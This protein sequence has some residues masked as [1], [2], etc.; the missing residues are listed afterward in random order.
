MS[1][2]STKILTIWQQLFSSQQFTTNESF[3]ALGGHTKSADKLY[4]LLV[5]TFGAELNISTTIAY[6]YPTIEKQVAYIDALLKNTKSTHDF[7]PKNRQNNQYEPVAIIGMA[8]RFPAGANTPQEYWQQLI[9][10]QDVLEE[11]PASRWDVNAYYHPNR[12]MRGKMVTHKG[13]FIT[14]HDKFD[15]YFFHIAPTE[16]D[17]LDPNQ[18]IA[19]ETSWHALEN[20][21]IDPASLE[22][23][24]TGVFMGVMF[25]DYEVL[26][27]RADLQKE[28]VGYLNIGTSSGAVAGRISYS[29][30]L[31]GPS[32]VIDTACSSSLTALHEACQHLHNQEC[33]LALAGGIN[34]MLLPEVSVSFS[35]ANMLSPDQC[36][37]SFSDDANGYVRS[38]GCGIVVLKRLSDAQK[39][40]DRILA[41]IKS[42]TVNQDGA[43]SG[44]TVPNR[45]AQEK[46]L[47][48]ALE[49]AALT[50]QDID[51]LEAH[52]TGTP[53]GDPI[54]MGAINTVYQGRQAPLYIGS[55]KSNIGHLE[56]ASG[57]AGLMKVILSLQ[58]EM[59]P[60]N[61]HFHALNPRINLDNIPAEIVIKPT[62]WQKNNKPR[63]AGISSFGF[64]GTNVHV[65][66][67]E[68]PLQDVTALKSIISPTV[69][70]RQRFWVKALDVAKLPS[71]DQTSIDED[72]DPIDKLSSVEPI[73]D[74]VREQVLTVLGLPID[75]KLHDNI[76]FFSLGLDSLMAAGLGRRINK[77]FPTV[78]F[79]I[80]I[81]F[82]YPS[83][84][85]LS[86]YIEAQLSGIKPV[87]AVNHIVHHIS[88]EPIAIIGMSCRFPGGAN[89]IEKFWQLL[90]Q[91]FDGGMDIPKE[92]WNMDAYYNT[93]MDASGKIYVRRAGL[94]TQPIDEFD[95]DFFG[96]SPREASYLDPQQRILLEETWL[97][98]EQAGIHPNDLKETQTS[99]FLGICS[100]DYL[101]RL[102]Q[103]PTT[104]INSHAGT[105][106][107]ASTAAGR[108]SYTLGLQGAS[109]AIDTACSSSLVAVHQACQNLRTNESNMAI[110]GGVNTILAPDFMATLCRMHML[111]P[112]G[113]C[114]TFDKEADGFMRGEGC[115]VIILK[116]LNDAQADGDRILA[117]IKGSAVNQDGATSGLT[118]PNGLAQE[119][120][121]K[122]ALQQA[123]LQPADIDY[124]E[125]HGTGTHLGD[126]IE[127]SA[128]NRVFGR[129]KNNKRALPLTI[130]TVKT[131]IGHLEA[132]AGIAGVIK[133]ILSMQHEKIPPH[134][135]FNALNPAINLDN[136][137]AQIPLH[138]MDWKK[139]EG[140]IRRAGVS[141]FG[142]SG[143]NAHIVLE[144]AP[145][146]VESSLRPLLPKTIFNRQRYWAQDLQ[147]MEFKNI[148]FHINPERH[149]LLQHEIFIPNSK[150]WLY[151]TYLTENWPDFVEDHLI[152]DSPVIAGATYVSALLSWI[153]EVKLGALAIEDMNFIE[154]L[155]VERGKQYHV[156]TLIES[157]NE[158]YAFSIYS[159]EHSDIDATWQL[160]VQGNL[161][162]QHK[163]R[164]YQHKVE[165]RFLSGK[166]QYNKTE[167]L[168]LFKN[169]S[170]T[171]GDHFHWLEEAWVQDH[172]VLA[173]FRQ[174]TEEEKSAAYVIHPGLM[175]SIFQ[176]AFAAFSEHHHRV[177]TPYIPFTLKKMYF[178]LTQTQAP[179][180]CHILFEPMPEQKS[181]KT[182][183][184]LLNDQFVCIGEVVDLIERCAPKEKLLQSVLNK[185]N[186]AQWFY[187]QVWQPCH[188]TIHDFNQNNGEII[189]Y[190][191]RHPDKQTGLIGFNLNLLAFIQD[192]ILKNISN[193]QVN[194]ITE[195][196]YSLFNESIQLDQA[197]LNGFIKTVILEHP[198]LNIRQVDVEK[199]QDIALLNTLLT[200][201][202]HT[203]QI[204]AY[205]KNQ[206][207]GVR[208]IKQEQYNKE[209]EVLN[210]PLEKYQLIKSQ[211]G[212]LEELTFTDL[213][214][215]LTCG[216]NEVIFQPKAIGLNFR[217]VLN[218]MNLY[219]GDPGP[220][221]SDAAGV[222]L[223]VGGK[224][225]RFCVGDEIM[226][227]GV[228]SL[229]SHAIAH[230]DNLMLKPSAMSFVEAASV[231]IVFLTAYQALIECAKL[232]AG[233][234]VL[235]HAAAG[236]VGL[237][238]IQIAQSVRANIIAT[239]GSNEKRAYLQKLGIVHIFNSRDLSYAD[240]VQG[241]T[242]GRGVDVVLNSLSG[243]G[244]IEASVSCCAKQARF[245]EIGKR[246]IW[247]TE[248]FKIKRPDMQYDVIALDNLIVH[249]PENIQN[250][251]K[252]VMDLFNENIL[253][254]NPLTCFPLDQSIIAFKYLQQAK[255]IG[256][257][258]IQMPVDELILNAKGSYLITGGLGGLGLEMAKFLSKKN[259]GRIILATRSKPTEQMAALIEQ[260]RQSGT[261]ILTSQ[262]DV[263]H[264]E[265]TAA[266]IAFSN[267]KE[268]PLKGIFHAAGS[269]CDATIDHQNA[270]RFE[271][272][273]SAKVNGAWYLHELTSEKNIKLD[274]FVLFS[275]MASL[276]GSVTQSNYAAANSF[277]D[278]LAQYRHQ[279]NLNAHSI[280]WGPWGQVGM[281]KDLA[282]LHARQ[283][284]I[285]FKPEQAIAA[286]EWALKQNHAQQGIMNIDWEK[287]TEQLSSIPS[288]LATLAVV[289]NK[290][291]DLIQQLSLATASERE[292]LFKKIITDEVRKTLG[293]SN[294]QSIDETKG[295]FEMGMDSFMA[296]ELK[297]RLQTLMQQSIE[298]TIAFDYP[299]IAELVE[300][301]KTL[302]IK[303]IGFEKQ[304]E[305]IFIKEDKT[306][307]MSSIAVIG[308]GCRFPGGANT[309]SA[310]WALL[311]QGFDSSI[312]VPKNRWNI[313]DYYDA[314]P[315]AKGKII[316]RNA[317]FLNTPI[318]EFDA[319]FFG[320]S[321]RE[322]EYL[323]PQQ[324][325]LLEV[326]WE[327]VENSGIHPKDL[328]NSRTGVF[329]GLATHDYGDLLRS[330]IPDESIDAYVGTGNIS[331]TAAGRISYTL[332]LK[333]PCCVVDTA[334]SSSLLAL[335][336]GC[337]SLRAKE[338]DLI[339]AGGVNV[340]LSPYL[341]INFSQAHMLAAD[342]HCKTFDKEAD[343]YVRGEGCGI[344]ILKRYQD[345][346]DDGDN[347]LAL[348][349]GSAVNQDGSSSGLTVPNGPSQEDVIKTALA[350]AQL[351]PDDI[352]Y[353]ETHGTGTRLGDP[354]EVN[355]ISHVFGMA[356]AKNKRTE[357]LVLG[358]VKT[359][360][361]HLEA[362]AGIA[363]V[364]KTI[365]SLQHEKIPQHLHFNSLNPS[366]DFAKI[367][368]KIP[369]Q[370]IAWKK[371]LH[372]IRRAGVSS[373]G[374]SGTNVH[375]I[376]EEAP[377]QALQQK[378]QQTPHV[379][380]RTRYWAK[381]LDE[382]MN[383]VSHQEKPSF[384]DSIEQ[385]TPRLD[386][387]QYADILALVREQVHIVLSLPSTAQVDE[388]GFFE[389]GLD[390]LMAAELARRITALFPAV[391]LSSTAAYDYPTITKLSA[392]I[393]AQMSGKKLSKDIQPTMTNDEPIA[394]IGLSCRFPGGANDPEQF[395]SLLEKGIDAGSD[396]SHQRWDMDKYYSNDTQKIGNIYTKR[397]GLLNVPIED[398]DAA[399]FGISPREA[400]LLDPQQRLL[401]ETTWEALENARI[402]P[403]EL[404]ESLTGV[405]IGIYSTDYKDE[406]QKH[407]GAE[408]VESYMATGNAN[409]TAVGRIS[410]TLGL[411]GPCFAID[412]A[413]SSALVAV[414]QACQSIR[415]GESELAI[416]GGVNIIFSPDAM[417]LECS[418]QMLS[419]DGKCKTFDKNADGFMRGEGGGIIILKKLSSA[420]QNGD[421]ILAV[422]KGS[423]VNQDG[424][425]SGL[426]V[427]NGPAQEEVIK[428]ALN[429]AQLK[430]DDIDY[431]EAHGTGTRVGDPIEI[432]AL[433]QV[434]GP[435]LTNN[436]RTA[437]LIIGTVKT[438]IGHTEAAAGIAG[439]IK[440]ILSLQH[441]EI[442]KHLHF[443]AVN[444]DIISF[445][446]MPAQ[447]PMVAIAWKKAQDHI[448]RAGVSSF[449][450]SGTN[451]HV[452][453]EEA[454]LQ[455]E[456]MLRPIL[457]KTVFNRRRYWPACF[458]Q[459]EKVLSDRKDTFFMDKIE[460]IMPCA[461]DL[462]ESNILELIRQQAL[463]VLVLD[464]S[465]HEQ[466]E[467]GFFDLGMDSLMASE[468][469]FR[470]SKLFPSLSLRS[471]AVYDY[472]TI[473]KLAHYIQAEVGGTQ[474]DTP[475]LQPDT[476]I[477]QEAIAIIGM[478]C[479]FPDGA[480]NTEQF[481]TLLEQAYDAGREI[482]KERWDMNDYYS[483]DQHE[484]GKIYTKRAGLLN[485][486][487]EAFDADFF[488]INAR[489]AAL[490]DPQQRLLLETT[491]EALE[492][493]GI[494]P[495]SLQDSLTGVFFGIYGT[496]YRDVLSKCDSR[497]AMDGYVATGNAG[498]TAT[499]RIAYTLGLK[500]PN[501]AID[502][503]CSSSLIAVHQA[504]QSLKHGESH[505]AIV[506][507]ANIILSPDI[508]MLECGL[509]M[510][511]PDGKCK[512][513]DKDA[514]GFMRGEGAG[515][516][517]L[518]RY[519]DAL[520]NN[521]TILAVIKGSAINQDGASSG[522]T[523]PNGL[524][525]EEVIAKALAQAQLNPDDI[526]YIE[527]H[528]TGTKLGDPIEI[529]AIA[530][531]FGVNKG[532]N[533]RSHALTIGT[534]KTN[535][536]HLE[537]AA[538]MAGL[539]KTVLALQHEKIPQHLHFNSLNPDIHLDQI[540]AQLPLKAINWKKEVGRKRRAGI[541]G[542]GFSGTNAHVVIEEAPE[543]VV[544]DSTLKQEQHLLCIFAKTEKSLQQ[545]IKRYIAYLNTTQ[546][547]TEN[548]CYTS[549]VAREEFSH[550]VAVLGKS[551]H[552]LSQHLEN[553][554]FV[555]ADEILNYKYPQTVNFH[556]VSLPTY[557]FD[558]QVYWVDALRHKQKNNV[559]GKIL[560]PLLGIRLPP[561][562]KQSGVV[563]Q[564]NI[565]ITEHAFLYLNDHQVF[566][567]IIFPAAGY[568]ELALS[569]MQYVSTQ[570]DVVNTVKFSHIS[571]D[572]PLVLNPQTEATVQVVV[573][574]DHLIEIYSQEK[575]KAW[576]CHAKMQAMQQSGLY[577]VGESLADI[578]NRCEL[579]LSGDEF[580]QT[581]GQKGLSYGPMF[582]LLQVIYKGDNEVYAELKI[583]TAIDTR[584]RAYPALLDC[585]LQ[586]ILA[587]LNHTSQTTLAEKVYVPAG[588]D[589]AIFYAALTSSVVVHSKTLIMRDDSSLCVSM[590]SIY[591]TEGL[592]LCTL[593]DLILKPLSVSQLKQLLGVND[594]RPFNKYYKE[595]WRELPCPKKTRSTSAGN[596]LLIGAEKSI[597]KLEGALTHAGENVIRILSDHS[598]STIYEELFN[599]DNTLSHIVYVANTDI[600]IDDLRSIYQPLL[601]L[602]QACIAKS[603][604]KV[605]RIYVITEQAQAVKTADCL[606][607]AQSILW[608]MMKI[609][610]REQ[611]FFKGKCID[612][613][614]MDRDL[615]LMI[616]ELFNETAELQV[617]LRGST[618]YVGRLIEEAMPL[619][620]KNCSFKADA[621][622]IITGGLGDIGLALTDWLIEHGAK[623][624]ALLSRRS[625]NDTYEEK[626][627][628]WQQQGVK[629][630]VFSI[631]I[632]NK[633]QLRDVLLRMTEKGFAALKGVF[634]TAGL[635]MDATFA[636]QTMD[637]Y[638]QVLAPK[639][640][641]AWYL[642]ELTK[643][644]P[645]DYFILFSS[646]ASL[647]GTEG[648]S[649][650]AAANTFLDRL[651]DY[652]RQQQYVGQ[653]IH[654]GAW[655]GIGY[656]AR[657]GIHD[658][659][660]MQLGTRTITP[661]E[662]LQC[663]EEILMQPQ[664]GSAS[665]MPMDW[666]IYFE[667][668]SHLTTQWDSELR[669]KKPSQITSPD[670]IEQLK[671]MSSQDR[672]ALLKAAI[673]QEVKKAFGLPSEQMI[674]TQKDFFEMGMDSLMVLDLKNRLQ[675]LTH[676]PLSNTLAL[677]YPNIDLLVKYFVDQLQNKNTDPSND[678]LI[679]F[680]KGTGK[681]PLFLIHG[682]DGYPESFIDL[683]GALDIK[684]SI[685]A[686]KCPEL[687]RDDIHLSTLQDRAALYIQY[688]REVQPHG[689]YHLLGWSMGGMIAVEMTNQLHQQGERIEFIGVIDTLMSKNPS[690]SSV[691]YD[692][693]AQFLYY[694]THSA[695]GQDVAHYTEI[696]VLEKIRQQLLTQGKKDLTL[697]QIDK[698]IKVLAKNMDQGM[699]YGVSI[700]AATIRQFIPEMETKK[701]HYFL[702]GEY[703]SLDKFIK[704]DIISFKVKGDHF[705]MLNRENNGLLVK[706]LNEF[707]GG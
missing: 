509:Q 502:T 613:E 237:A 58:H 438:N 248:Q 84:T 562:A 479:R 494:K 296:L 342:G 165:E 351:K 78:K 574:S 112:V 241:I 225:Q 258:V 266:L 528:G 358:T 674:D 703:D 349:K 142:F 282:V 152:F 642:H 43:S 195:Q 231:P 302:P 337:Q 630:E 327:A 469:A 145:S 89:D 651:I 599:D 643:R 672:E 466:D 679:C 329:I 323:D 281:A 81:A 82:D 368:A 577:A 532:K 400:I 83:I 552:E 4:K 445:D 79:D 520:K 113:Y 637:T 516:V 140:K 197:L 705:S 418:M 429:Q 449:S 216:D 453:V 278:G 621:S 239:V 29:L 136:I 44:M 578:K 604:Q 346:L 204:I 473:A 325:L 324:R 624:I 72:D 38:E 105:G 9:E 394:V 252:K 316:S 555:S 295:F 475:V 508:M 367:P 287:V 649:N 623:Q 124:I 588:I 488:G 409:S 45:L 196:A 423:A 229:S 168:Q 249:S 355:A 253:K 658:S 235:I 234:T 633:Q 108:I 493:A 560:H 646:V 538:G 159:K 343:G 608:G 454:P 377:Q 111:S 307:D 644:L 405:F 174:P 94:L 233:E 417:V 477:T 442:P 369:L 496:D 227:F 262:C 416:A 457:A 360:I 179:S 61:L 338:S 163:M 565:A 40:G 10:G 378:F 309:I 446:K 319:Q 489:E 543:N 334:C 569:A 354:I 519:S 148:G 460:Q 21:G 218:A 347:I 259:V 566:D 495:Y 470:I 244:F 670:F 671:I 500:G 232:K 92:R 535:V 67:E 448:R 420:L 207:Y 390:S 546:D 31:Q 403:L 419:P 659:D 255:H 663:F 487:I 157:N 563:F 170:I 306:Q 619:L 425:S 312:E 59:I 667:H 37:K 620:T 54:E 687:V 205:R 293:L 189:F 680:K 480:N 56:A 271:D 352:D 551:N 69:F 291:T 285:Y 8:C 313:D 591:S 524:A 178:N 557:A 331:S 472:P 380:Q 176:S 408:S 504:C 365:L 164:P 198:E 527:T 120:V 676:Q 412:T 592:L 123:M 128:L 147:S 458:E 106:N 284:L 238:A 585:C 272:V 501:F 191:A 683:A 14:D 617:A 681:K 450:F 558:R 297:N 430:P 280:N 421:P 134:L 653:T 311:E 701:L 49:L 76:G 320:I 167:H 201:A 452:I 492:A 602:L 660:V 350:Q 279:H 375:M 175:D 600:L 268:Y 706:Y 12:K 631:D 641:G 432:N 499:G 2:T 662:A 75:E 64:T 199:N 322:A 398:F 132:A 24:D 486:P 303:N 7:S 171:L 451:A 684:R 236:G 101:D 484:V 80:T 172:E 122:Q 310:F 580:Y 685:Y 433:Y 95:A 221:G 41:V 612:V 393:E 596:W 283:G 625:T 86:A 583:N 256:K 464:A 510:L 298:N 161:S 594:D 628:I 362:A 212:L 270:Q 691:C 47:T 518:K 568:L 340:L 632:T 48:Q 561:M 335:H 269:L 251:F 46:L 185:K 439:M 265:Q 541:S 576:Q 103:M 250:L 370:S 245:V 668:W 301:I 30:G 135:H 166:S 406:L 200:R 308:I 456:M 371:Q 655:A 647:I 146:Q 246:E 507:G 289:N 87:V 359:N 242:K 107:A 636:E 601:T 490:L 382:R 547:R 533:K 590:I 666:D 114:K 202:N 276:K 93:E 110:V 411:R 286:L 277:L 117:V 573:G 275:S 42:S 247:T 597:K 686:I 544:I 217:D 424:A 389:Q 606:Y 25:H 444:P 121:I 188:T 210:I 650:Y 635:V 260:M 3:I 530:Q 618:R 503:A 73:I 341:S 474:K 462:S 542:F 697:A 288:W 169:L 33:H 656:A 385:M 153:K 149:P 688:L 156:Q 209:H 194:I 627:Q 505:L 158:G 407:D 383:S 305:E 413:C 652:R 363:G 483:S 65:L 434:F 96:I 55:V 357:A 536:G 219:P 550:K 17:F 402:N 126:P 1:N 23:T 481:W 531:I 549:Q 299:S 639:V 376:L 582:R 116:R 27:D 695:N 537:A 381:C 143:T 517:I 186:M 68:A 384:I 39:A 611:P 372:H 19:L 77:L 180:W 151:E 603:W 187:T 605:P 203:E 404:Q 353:I 129:E 57:I 512:T 440:T 254:C 698:N 150:N 137:P 50:P 529:N 614:S 36:C 292:A 471:S 556:K 62:H 581:I 32:M 366:I 694:L 610:M 609:L 211:T 315:N 522:L 102:G 395:W 514:N 273:F 13:G 90:E 184:K 391:T 669:V 463:T 498:S 640:L 579:K 468:L 173:K 328:K 66:V 467:V 593:K 230:Q 437:P 91:G 575:N 414:H 689:P 15:A 139:Q 476:A 206:W 118:V 35:R 572:Q 534:V 678:I 482:P 356:D 26:L 595:V 160:H 115:G 215:S 220:L 267:S 314:N 290:S 177:V 401:L 626:K 388:L 465:D 525:Q 183:I 673:S 222:I 690:A 396:M 665:V 318:D 548:I 127:V 97:A 224:V 415:N 436:K 345:A 193:V 513:F 497:D 545:Q 570:D 699:H 387:H 515:I 20:A 228:G 584:Y 435:E 214:Y 455:D 98:L 192:L 521:D 330:H 332:G 622:Y 213:Y 540:P 336:Q 321:P 18:R 478:S 692:D 133:T 28:S 485:V 506:G 333:G 447:I 190:D 16:A 361:G 22:N 304:P 526:D 422:I 559:Q 181:V 629:V 243:Q 60:A 144:E 74:A 707:L 119:R 431:I 52:G 654:W 51:Y 491:W 645:L 511:S 85:K 399:F 373:F 364:I 240:D 443:N 261:L 104:G 675:T 428:K 263:S 661:E 223:A 130:G 589:E 664:L 426:T 300:H 461:D 648:Q 11:I 553:E 264:K 571:F 63:R 374:F 5:E 53:L 162:L 539:I 294:S 274:Y 634:H 344:I 326:T 397:A 677:D 598:N 702:K 141:S 616:D 682:V 441:E 638:Q 607:P 70:N 88:H 348:I 427:P 317:S 657:I 100:R 386:V 567:D 704:S 138:V 392:Y 339:V 459:T 554:H 34:L 125:A 693:A 71:I 226:G 410:Y 615:P 587:L 155:I 586:S 257:V 6:D 182:N 696:N 564:Q 154:A 131:N 700:C 523:V 99:V 379:F 109:I 208:V